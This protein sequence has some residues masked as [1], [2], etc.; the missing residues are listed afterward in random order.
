MEKDITSCADIVL[1]Y[2]IVILSSSLVIGSCY[3]M[4]QVV[5]TIYQQAARR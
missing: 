3:E 1:N 5:N 2:H 4:N